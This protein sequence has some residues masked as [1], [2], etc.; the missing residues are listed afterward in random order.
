MDKLLHRIPSVGYAWIIYL[1]LQGGFMS[2]I[3]KYYNG[4]LLQW[5]H[6]PALT[7]LTS[8]DFLHLPPK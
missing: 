3:L 1:Q 7:S 2:M 4:P 6:R 5:P 8:G